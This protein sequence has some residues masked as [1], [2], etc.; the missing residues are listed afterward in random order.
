MPIAHFLDLGPCSVTWDPD[1]LDVELNPTFGGVRYRDTLLSSPIME[2]GQGETEIDG[3]D[4]GRT[5]EVEV[6]MTRFTL[7][8]LEYVIAGSSLAVDVLTVSNTVGNSFYAQAKEILIKPMVDNVES[9][10][11]TQWVH[12]WKCYPVIDA[13]VVFDNSEQRIARVIFKVFPNQDTTGLGEMY[14]HG[15]A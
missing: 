3:V 10:T 4:K 13:E 2:D 1:L 5:V 8:Q 11:D 15:T 7:T 12:F 14:T 9:V 6:P